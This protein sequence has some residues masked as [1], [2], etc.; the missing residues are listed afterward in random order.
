MFPID[1]RNSARAVES[2]RRAAA[3]I[4]ERPGFSFGILPEGTRTLDGRIGPFKRGG[5]LLAVETGLDVLPVV[6][7]G[8]FAVARKGSLLIRPG[9]VEIAIEPAVPI[10]GY[11][12]ENVGELIG[13]V[14]GIF[15][16]RLGRADA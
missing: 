12:K 3:W 16:D 5:F 13:R 8:A 9:R 6:Q 15:L 4:R 2:L 10:S 7:K 1:R 11:A 14:R